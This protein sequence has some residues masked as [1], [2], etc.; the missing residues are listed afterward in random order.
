MFI[1]ENEGQSSLEGLAALSAAT[2]I[3]ILDNPVLQTLDGLSGFSERI[4]IVEIRR[5]DTL[6]GVSGLMGVEEV[7]RMV[8]TD[9]PNLSMEDAQLLADE[10]DGD[11]CVGSPEISDNGGALSRA[12]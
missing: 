11:W 5:N 12:P 6:G 7:C 10:L 9:N 3:Y 4:N 1:Q 8:I 2:N